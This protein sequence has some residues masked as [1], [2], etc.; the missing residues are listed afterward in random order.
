MRAM[1]LCFFSV[2]PSVK[3]LLAPSDDS[4]KQK[5]SCTAWGFNPHI[6]WLSGSQ[7]I[8]SGSDGS[9]SLN[10]EGHVVV[11]SQLQ[12]SQAEW[13]TGKVFSCQVSDKSL[14]KRLKEDI[15]VCAGKHVKPSVCCHL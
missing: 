6:E 12:V 10:S 7:R 1:G 14:N 4:G 3:L 9:I 15:S 8:S 5:L 11:S 13:K 2:D